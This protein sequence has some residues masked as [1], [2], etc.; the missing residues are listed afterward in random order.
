MM[1]AQISLDKTAMV[2]SSKLISSRLSQVF[3]D[4][5]GPHRETTVNLGIDFTPGTSRRVRGRNAKAKTR[6][7]AA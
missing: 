4:L 3:G 7:N 5:V 1:R 2:S 6:M